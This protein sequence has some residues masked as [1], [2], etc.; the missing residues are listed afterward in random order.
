MTLPNLEEPRVAAP[1]VRAVMAVTAAGV[2]M[3]MLDVTIVNIA[4]DDLVGDFR[5][6]TLAML[7]WVVNGYGITFAAGLLP[8]GRL[9]DRLGARTVFVGGVALF[10]AASFA[11]GLAP[12]P[13]WLVLAR[14]IQALGA[15]A[16][17]PSAQ[18][19]LLGVVSLDRR[20]RALALI[21]ATGAVAAATGP[22]LGGA[23]VG[24]FG[25]RS[26]FLVNVP[27]TLV[28][29]VVALRVLP[30]GDRRPS[31]AAGS[32]LV[33]ALLAFGVLGLAVAVVQSA[34][35]GWGD[36]RTVAAGVLGLAL[37][38][39]VVV[40]NLRGG[41][42]AL[43][44]GSFRQGPVWVA[45]AASFAFA[46]G[47]FAL[48]LTN[49]LFLTRLFDDVT[50]AG[51]ALTPGAVTAASVATVG[52]RFVDRSGPRRVA[53]AGGVLF[54]A[55]CLY[56]ATQATGGSY[57]AGVLPG[58]L[59]TGAGIGLCLPALGTAS[60]A[61][62]PRHQ[63]GTASALNA[64][65]RQLGGVLGVAVLLTLLADRGQTDAT[66]GAAWTAMAGAGLLAAATAA[67]LPGRRPVPPPSLQEHS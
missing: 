58:M 23:L 56:L 34:T 31:T 67:I 65:V 55:G 12:G 27:V 32:A 26:V 4:F 8:A 3:S 36:P 39:A 5:G 35:W 15:A 62:V 2:F 66:F 17:I 1:R 16:L 22:A 60:V 28:V 20:G 19:A 57:V 21:G 14:V 9:A 64:C 46:T 18:A 37:M 45:N 25:W 33:S 53:V 40:L 63:Y 13:A 59:L 51:L 50:T 48:L 30:S 7:S 38:V 61:G 44:G 10:G 54:A 42:Y 24:A 43:L 47:F 41:R 49:A 52:G 29:V 6:V 11:C